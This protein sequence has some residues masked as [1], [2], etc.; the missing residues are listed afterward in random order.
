MR[1][2]IISPY[3]RVMRNGKENPKNYPYWSEVIKGL[4]KKKLH[5]IQIGVKN[6]QRLNANDFAFDK[7]LDELSE[8]I[9]IC[10]AWASVDNFFHHLCYLLEKPGVV[11]F[12]KSDPKIFGH[13]LNDN[14]LKDRSYLRPAQFNFW[15]D[16]EY[17]TECFIEP[18]V[19]VETILR[20]V[21]NG[22]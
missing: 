3:S 5:V 18:Q 13:E 16:V 21:S 19:V 10:T 6:E 1:K 20:R 17:S 11:I 12:G 4:Q 9:K 15:E 22:N 7:S 2:V 14:L 8:L